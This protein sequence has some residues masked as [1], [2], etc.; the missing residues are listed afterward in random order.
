[1]VRETEATF[2]SSNH[3]A[4]SF[5]ESVTKRFERLSHS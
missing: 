1:M 2:E 4:Q 3:F 5:R